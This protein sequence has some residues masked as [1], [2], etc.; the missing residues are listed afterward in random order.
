VD[1]ILVVN[2]SPLIHLAEAGRL[3]LLRDAGTSVWV[4]EPVGREIR[5]FGAEDPTARAHD[6]TAWLLARPAPAIPAEIIAW[7]LGPGESSVLALARQTPSA[8][9]VIDD[10]AGRRC[11]EAL[12][13]RLLGTVGLV[14]LARREG[15]ISSAREVL[16]TLRQHGMYLSDAVIEA[17][18]A[19]VGE[20]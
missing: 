13:V 10:L 5:A 3:D 16:D 12:G 17:A 1:R 2:A 18:L 4:P 15:R 7:D 9:A 11:A 19:L 20:R 6:Q 8:S 14:L